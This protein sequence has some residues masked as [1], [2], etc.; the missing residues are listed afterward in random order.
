MDSRHTQPAHRERETHFAPFIYQHR[1]YHHDSIHF[2]RA[3]HYFF[4]FPVRFLLLFFLHFT[5]RWCH[6]WSFK[7]F[8]D[9]A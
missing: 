6:A 1:F 8:V 5:L 9:A 2:I 3:M 4:L 7:L